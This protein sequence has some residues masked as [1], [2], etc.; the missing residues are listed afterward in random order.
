MKAYKKSL[1]PELISKLN[2]LYRIKGSWWQTIVDDD[3]VFI[4]VRDNHLRVQVHGGLLL[5]ITIDSRGRLIC[6]THEEYLSLRSGSDPY[7]T[8]SESHTSPPKRVEGLTEFITHYSKIKRR[9]K[10]FVGNERQY[11][12]SISLNITETVDKEVGLVL[13]KDEDGDRK[14][15]QFVDLQAI[16]NDGTLVFV[17]A[18]LMGNQEIRSSKVPPVVKQ[19]QKYQTIIKSH[20]R[21]II[22]AYTEQF[23]TY[24]CLSG[25]FFQKKLPNPSKVT[26]YPNVR[27]L[28]T[29]FDSAQ[30]KFLMPKIRETIEKGMD[31][32]PNTNDIITIGKPNSINATHI[33]KGI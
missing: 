23:E 32:E 28:I 10:Q 17:E 31:W 11:C 22:N 15:A 20:K 16:S 29:D 2:E 30:L 27:L 26:I 3:Q 8:I 5:M 6:K 24:S 21:K 4:L 12:H 33:F 7:V 1:K 19:L 13:T 14:K 18:K 9:I 25:K